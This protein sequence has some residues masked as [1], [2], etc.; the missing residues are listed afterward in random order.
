M[1]FLF[2]LHEPL[3]ICQTVSTP[4]CILPFSGHMISYIWKSIGKSHLLFLPLSRF[5]PESASKN[6]FKASI[7]LVSGGFKSAKIPQQIRAVMQNKGRL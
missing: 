6:T 4:S 5:V 2:P 3:R 1:L 7:S